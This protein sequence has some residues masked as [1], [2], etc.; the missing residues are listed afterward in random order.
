VVL[1]NHRKGQRHGGSGI[2]TA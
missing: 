2:D 1:L